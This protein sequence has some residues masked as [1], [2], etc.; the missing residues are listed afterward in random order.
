MPPP[1]EDAMDAVRELVNNLREQ[2]LAIRRDLHR[3][4][5]TGFNE[6]KTSEYVAE[7]RKSVV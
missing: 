5:E 4:P 1:E 7:D 6:A 3:I 2:V